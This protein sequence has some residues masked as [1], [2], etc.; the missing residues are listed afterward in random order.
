M[1]LFICVNIF[2]QAG[3]FISIPLDTRSVSMGNTY[4]AGA[5]SNAIYTNLAAS[6]LS[7]KKLELGF[8][9]RPWIQ[10]ISDDYSITGFSALF[11]LNNKHHIA[12]GNRNYSL[13]SYSLTDDNG[14]LSEEY[15][16]KEYTIDL[17]YAYNLSEKTALSVS[18]H[19]IDADY[20]ESSTANTFGVDL[21]FKSSYKNVEFGAMVRNLGSELEFENSTSELPL[22][23]TAG[24]AYTKSLLDKHHL[25]ANIDLA[26]V[27]YND[28]SGMTA[29]VG[30]E[31]S[32]KTYL[33][34]R[35]GYYYADEAIGLETF[36][37]G[38]GVKLAGVSIDFAW[39]NSDNALN[40]NYSLSCSW[41]LF[42]NKIPVVDEETY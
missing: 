21:G 42:K 8:T 11:A 7:N 14:N 33:A 16:P 12:L 40:N 19:Y 15:E 6:S 1:A 20:G 24:V 36:S 31:Y 38:C 18:F 32:Y 27:S 4:V 9:Y 39:L 23:L 37:L 34:L 41:A 2:S 10:D 25:A 30:V 22:T 5:H 17:G 29:G 3:S 26:N 28:E 35:T 13:P